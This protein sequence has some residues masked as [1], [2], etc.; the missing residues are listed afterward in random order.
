LTYTTRGQVT[1]HPLGITI[2]LLLVGEHFL[3]GVAEREVQGLRGEIADDIG[4][5]TTPQ[6]DNAFIGSGA[7]E[8]VHDA[9][10][11]AIKTASL[12]HFIL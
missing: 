2:P 5:I 4:R 11:F 10:V 6:R 8:A 3:V 9:I 7:S 12:D 1:H